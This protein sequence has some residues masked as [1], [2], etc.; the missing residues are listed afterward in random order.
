MMN[1]WRFIAAT[2]IS[3]VLVGT[4]LESWIL[5][6]GLVFIAWKCAIEYWHLAKPSRW[7]TNTLTVLSLAIIL[8]KFRTLMSQDSSAGFL[9]LL[10]SLKL[11]EERTLRDQKFLF[12]LGFV[13]IS[14]LLLFSLEIPALVGGLLSF[15]LLWTAQNKAITYK[16]SFLRAA[17]LALVLFL[18]FPRVQNPFGIQGLGVNNQGQTG[19]SDEMNPGSI[20]KIQSSKELAFRAQ[21]LNAKLKPRM[22]EQ[23]WR[24]QILNF[25]EGLRWTQGPRGSRELKFEKILSPDY[26]VTLEPTSRRWIF[27]FD[28]TEMVQSNEFGLYLKNKSYFE[29]VA[30]IRDRAVYRGQIATQANDAAAEV[31]DLQT[32]AMSEELQKFVA[33]LKSTSATTEIFVEK[34]LDHYRQGKFR[35]SKSPG[36]S[37]S[38]GSGAVDDFFFKN[39]KGYCEHYAATT[40]L[41][42]RL[43]KIPAHVVTG[44]QGGEYNGYGNFWKFTQADAHA[45]VEYRN[46][47]GRWVRLDPTSVVAPER[48]ELG[49]AMFE[50][51]P[52]E[53]VGQNRAAEFLKY[54]ESWWVRAKDFITMT[55]ESL[56]Y[57]LVV[58]LLDFNLEKQKELLREYG[59]WLIGLVGLALAPFVLQSFWRRRRPTT[60][61]WLLQQLDREAAVL[62]LYRRNG[63]TLRQFVGRWS[64]KSP[65]SRDSLNT[66]L[67]VYE[68]SEYHSVGVTIK[69]NE[70]RAWLK[71]LRQL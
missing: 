25:T 34:I 5:V 3:V 63:E 24:G 32:P 49:G 61:E 30:P 35:Y 69:R 55:A 51:L 50:D 13:L 36:V 10:T 11:L 19:F 33:E 52:E 22:L 42:L 31:L 15:Y 60:A 59:Y 71:N 1:T 53:W 17:P 54:R 62:K 68:T 7:L 58:F 26:E 70:L 57:D 28:P 66:I 56:N 45:W 2:L 9:V 47:Q 4:E 8:V 23:Y 64:E 37:S 46:E 20:A 43:A 14:S 18:L 41:I 21:F 65:S 16:N 40:A 67:Q 38:T 48:L 44:Y 27:T 29:A 6:A 12:L 39:K